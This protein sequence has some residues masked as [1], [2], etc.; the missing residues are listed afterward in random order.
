MAGC[1]PT[2]SGRVDALPVYVKTDRISISA[3]RGLKIPANGPLG[4]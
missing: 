4:P 2:L 3:S 1:A